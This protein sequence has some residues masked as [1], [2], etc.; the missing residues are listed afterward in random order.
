MLTHVLEENRRLKELTLKLERKA[1][2][3]RLYAKSM[4]MRNPTLPAVNMKNSQKGG[5]TTLDDG[6]RSA[7]HSNSISG[8]FPC[9]ELNLII[10]SKAIN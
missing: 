3:R 6:Q 10:F 7:K 8:N 5:T 2:D 4:T 1:N 9:Q